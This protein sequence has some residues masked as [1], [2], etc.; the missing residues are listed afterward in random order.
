MADK[1]LKMDIAVPRTIYLHLQTCM[2]FFTLAMLSGCAQHVEK[3]LPA[4]EP[5]PEITA[6]Y[7]LEHGIISYAPQFHEKI[8]ATLPYEIVTFE[9]SYLVCLVAR[10]PDPESRAR[11]RRTEA[12]YYLWLQRKSGGWRDFTAVYSAHMPD[13]KIHPHYSS[14]RNGLFYKDYTIEVKPEMLQKVQEN[15]AEFTLV[16]NQN[17]R[18]TIAIPAD[19]IKAFLE[20]LKPPSTVDRP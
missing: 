12:S 18:S 20:M 19:Y 14:I 1:L 17:I 5:L 13:L 11:I 9:E 2:L 7:L 3:P 8:I 15:G 10:L 4:P 16:N 6:D